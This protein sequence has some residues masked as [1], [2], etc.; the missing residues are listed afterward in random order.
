[1]GPLNSDI[2]TIK[3]LMRLLEFKQRLLAVIY[4]TLLFSSNFVEEIKTKP[5]K[6]RC[7]L[8]FNLFF[9]RASRLNLQRNWR[10]RTHPELIDFPQIAAPP[11]RFIDGPGTSGA[12]VCQ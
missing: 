8:T 9:C 6:A 10:K 11:L 7:S 3:T 5:L 2:C 4:P 12:S 1:M